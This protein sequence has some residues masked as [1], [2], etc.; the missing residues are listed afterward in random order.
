M[1]LARNAGREPFISALHVDRLGRLWIGTLTQGLM[2]A[3]QPAGNWP[4]VAQINPAPL[5]DSWS[6]LQ[7]LSIASNHDSIMVGT[8]GGGVLR[9]PLADPDVRLLTRKADGS[10]LRNKSVSAVLGTATAGQPWVG[11]LGPER[12]DVTTGTVIATASLRVGPD[13]QDQRAQPGDHRGR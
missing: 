3:E 5:D 2:V 12:V 4:D 8:W 7:P 13:P 10:G 6:A 1:I 9:A 11:T